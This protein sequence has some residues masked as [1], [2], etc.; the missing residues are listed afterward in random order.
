[1]RAANEAIVITNNPSLSCS[2]NGIGTLY[3]S[4]SALE[5]MKEAERLIYEGYKLLTH[6][7]GAN[8]QMNAGPYKTIFLKKTGAIDSYSVFTISKCV[9]WLRNFPQAELSPQVGLD[10]TLLDYQF[11]DRELFVNVLTKYKASPGTY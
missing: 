6:P 2:D 9:M 7:L 1:M 5:V 3:R 4:A 10:K 8:W 11:I